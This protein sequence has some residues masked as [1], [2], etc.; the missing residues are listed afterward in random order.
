MEGTKIQEVWD[1]LPHGILRADT[2]RYL[3][4]LLRGGIYSDTDTVL[5]KSPSHWGQNARLWNDGEGWLAEDQKK[6]LEEGAQIN[7]VLGRPSVIVGL[8][9]DVGDREDWYDWWPRPVS[10]NLNLNKMLLSLTFPDTN[11]SMDNGFNS[12]P[13]NRAERGPSHSPFYRHCRFLGT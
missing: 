3:L 7:E 9:A 6:R 1:N 10:Y 4:L 5:L 8:E 11:G 2:L 12:L 13:S